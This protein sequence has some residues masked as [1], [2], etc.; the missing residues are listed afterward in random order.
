[1]FVA[2]NDGD[3][4]YA[5]DAETGAPLW[6]AGPLKTHSLLGVAGTKLVV[7]IAGPVRGVRAFD[8]ATGA[9]FGNGGGWM[10]HDDPDLGTFGHG[11]V[12]DVAVLW[13]TKGGLFPLA[14]ADGFLA[15]PP[16]SGPQGNLAYADGVLIVATPIE[17][18]GYVVGPTKT[19]APHAAPK[20]RIARTGAGRPGWFPDLAEELIPP[21][22]PAKVAKT[23]AIPHVDGEFLAPLSVDPPLASTPTGKVFLLTGDSPQPLGAVGFRPTFVKPMP[24]DDSAILAGPDGVA[25][26]RTAAPGGVDWT[27]SAPGYDLNHFRAAGTQVVCR[28]GT[29]HLIAFNVRTGE[30][31]WVLDA[32]NRTEYHP[33]QLPTAPTFDAEFLLDDTCAIA[34]LSTGRCWTIDALSG[35]QLRDDPAVGPE[36]TA[37]PIQLDGRTV[38]VPTGPGAITAVYTADGRE[39]WTIRAGREASLSGEFPQLHKTSGLVVV[40]VRRNIGV[41]LHLVKHLGGQPWTSRP[42][43]LPADRFDARHVDADAINLYCPHDDRLTAFELFG[44]RK[45]WTVAL[46]ATHGAADWV[47]QAAAGAVVVFPTHAIPDEPFPVCANRVVRSFLTLP[48]ARRV[49]GLSH[50]LYEGW[51]ART[52]PI[53]VLDPDTGREIRRFDLPAFGPLALVSFSPGA[54]MTVMTGT[55]VYT[56]E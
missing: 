45:A 5:L 18:R 29:H 48:I 11:L 17:V 25:R 35:K 6:T 12:S 56:L 1:V 55:K 39:R 20:I 26:L 53:L 51:A 4:V 9:D 54:G 47:A 49:A 28:A 16:I 22:A 50:T 19:P 33:R 42:P 37:P 34:H 38:A 7:A 31:V 32:S 14:T 15:A 21:P 3:A 13:P 52:V 2:P 41:E 23:A 24:K 8:V 30:T 43:F 27:A 44:G 10:N 36:W 46:P 40:A